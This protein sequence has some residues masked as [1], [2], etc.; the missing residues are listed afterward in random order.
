M[1]T[2][3]DI[4]PPHKKYTREIYGHI[5]WNNNFKQYSVSCNTKI[6]DYH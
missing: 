1:T 6:A 3:Y 4:T 5:E 2:N